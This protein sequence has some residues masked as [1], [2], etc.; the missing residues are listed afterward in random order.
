MATVADFY[1]NTYLLTHQQRYQQ[2]TQ[3]AMQEQQTAFAIAQMLNAQAINLDKQIKAI[4]DAE[5]EDD[6]NKLM[7]AYGMQEQVR[8]SQDKRRIQ[9]YNQVNDIF[10]IQR[11]L[12]TINN[13]GE[14]FASSLASA[15]SVANKAKRYAGTVGG[16]SRATDQ[17]KAV[18]SAIYERFKADAYRKGYQTTFDAN[19]AAIRQE[20]ADITG[21]KVSDIDTVEAQ[22]KKMLD[23][24][25]RTEGAQNVDLTTL[26]TIIAEIE[27]DIAAEEAGG[28]GAVDPSTKQARIDALLTQR[29]ALTEQQQRALAT[30][31]RAPEE[32]ISRARTIYRSQ[33]APR[34]VQR[35]EA[36][37]NYLAR[38]DPGQAALML[39]YESVKPG[40]AKFM[41]K[42]FKNIED[43][44]TKAAAY[45]LYYEMQK[46]REEGGSFTGN[47]LLHKRIAE[48][49]PNDTE[50][51]NKAIGYILRATEME[52]PD[53]I[54][55]AIKRNAELQALANKKD[56]KDKDLSGIFGGVEAPR[57][58]GPPGGRPEGDDVEELIEQPEPLP[59]PEEL[60]ADEVIE[61][62]PVGPTPF[63]IGDVLKLD[64][65]YSYGYK[66]AGTTSGGLPI[67]EGT[68]DIAGKTITGAPADGDSVIA[69]P[70]AKNMYNEAYKLYKAGKK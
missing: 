31:Q 36:F 50:A 60:T 6:F 39:G 64:P 8:T 10:D 67:F 57:D 26:D 46:I 23:D 38:L 19:D 37:Q 65:T 44:P 33:Y 14:S 41:F 9:I 25:L 61:A 18:G 48:L 34:D 2:A 40:Q 12:P 70:D 52:D 51:Q 63:E 17:A 20:I 29:T 28:E 7:K 27:A 5:T 3:L 58:P 16:Y 47:D 22:K 45:T 1:T 30:A 21:I 66:Y 68:G 35:K 49:L 11:S 13:A 59:D 69:D 54:A 32:T 42:P 56:F 55:N 43:D 24:R 4:K 53:S 62:A 15:G